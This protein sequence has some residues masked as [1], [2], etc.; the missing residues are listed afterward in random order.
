MGRKF[1]IFVSFYSVFE[2]NFQ[3]PPGA[4]IRRG[5]LMDGF[6]R[7]EFWGLIF[8]EAYF[9]NLIISNAGFQHTNFSLMNS[10]TLYVM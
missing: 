9:R 10:T 5:D 3:F 8:G 1:T 6:L 2:D 4:D 7:Y